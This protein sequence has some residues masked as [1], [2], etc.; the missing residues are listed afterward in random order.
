MKIPGAANIHR[1]IFHIMRQT[2]PTSTLQPYNSDKGTRHGRKDRGSSEHY[3]GSATVANPVDVWIDG[4][5]AIANQYADQLTESD[6]T[7]HSLGNDRRAPRGAPDRDASLPAGARH[8]RLRHRHARIVRSQA[9]C[10]SFAR[11]AGK[12]DRRDKLYPG[13]RGLRH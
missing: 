12:R 9:S 8:L 7:S 13:G 5:V 6:R 11:T 3:T 10:A 1:S 4:C 2:P